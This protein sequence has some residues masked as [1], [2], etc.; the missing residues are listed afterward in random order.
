[1][2]TDTG[3]EYRV[4]LPEHCPICGRLIK[5]SE[6]EAEKIVAGYYKNVL[7]LVHPKCLLTVWRTE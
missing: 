7:A 2:I 3:N 5:H 1:M 6:I 4:K